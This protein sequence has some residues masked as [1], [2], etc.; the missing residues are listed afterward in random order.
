MDVLYGVASASGC[1][2][3]VL[4]QVARVHHVG[5]RDRHDGVDGGAVG[6]QARAG[7]RDRQCVDDAEHLGGLAVAQRDGLYGVARRR[8]EQRAPDQCLIGT[9]WGREWVYTWKH[10]K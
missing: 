3:D 5:P 8:V 7:R 4:H 9:R 10:G 1:D 6:R 2:G